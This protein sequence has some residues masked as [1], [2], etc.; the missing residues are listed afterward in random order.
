MARLGRYD[1]EPVLGP[2]RLQSGPQQRVGRH[3]P[4]QA[5]RA[6][7]PIGLG[8]RGRSWSP[9]RRRR[10]AGT[11]PPRPR[12]GVGVGLH[13]PAP[14]PFSDPRTRSRRPSAGSARGKAK[15]VGS[16]GPGR[17]LDRRPARV[18]EAEEPGH[19]VEGLAGGVV[20]GPAE[21][22]V[23]AGAPRRHQQ[24]VAARHQ[25]H[26]QRPR[27]RSGCSSRAANRWPSR[28]LTPTKGTSQARESALA[29]ATPTSRAPIRPGPEWRATAISPRVPAPVRSSPA[30]AR[31]SASD[32]R[33]Q[34]HVGPSGELGDDPAVAGVQVDLAPRPP[35]RRCVGPPDHGGGRLVARGLDAEDA[36]SGRSACQPW[37]RAIG[38]RPEPG[39]RMA[40]PFV[41]R[42]LPWCRCRGP[43]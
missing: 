39:G 27:P 32:R 15:A 19:L 8:R 1:R 31:A 3:A 7:A 9:A 10:P 13:G 20:D 37:A 24:G 11:R 34:L 4:G 42:L 38:A 5:Q 18:A 17:R 2:G 14:R 26:H 23:A 29:S 33:Q 36:A 40:Q 30:P 41:R 16:P 43:T 25:Q 12:G 6:R 28:W 21:Q 22:P 35:T